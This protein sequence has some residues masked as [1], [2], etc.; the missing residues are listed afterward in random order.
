[1][2]PL[3][4]SPEIALRRTWDGVMVRELEDRASVSILFVHRCQKNGRCFLL[5]LL[6]ITYLVTHDHRI[7]IRL[8]SLPTFL[9]GVASVFLALFVFQLQGTQPA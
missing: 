4:S 2:L 6:A 8:T 7:L 9:I 1:M 3:A 5:T